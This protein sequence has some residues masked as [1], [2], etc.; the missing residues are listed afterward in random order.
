MLI[1][2][3]QLRADREEGEPPLIELSVVTDVYADGLHRVELLGDNIRIVYFRWKLAADG[4]WQKIA[5]E[6]AFV[7]PYRALKR[8]LEQ[9]APIS[10]IGPPRPGARL[11]N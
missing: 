10:I 1:E 5:A 4:R 9:W 7:M 3:E 8:P 11:M 2:E 6:I